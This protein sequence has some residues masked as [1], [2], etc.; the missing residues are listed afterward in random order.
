MLRERVRKAEAEYHKLSEEAAI[1]Q[2]SSESS[3]SKQLAILENE[4]NDIERQLAFEKEE[5][6]RLKDNALQLEKEYR[7]AQQVLL[8]KEREL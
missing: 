5:L 2:A 8:L 1:A 4:A 3:V 6:E 7:R